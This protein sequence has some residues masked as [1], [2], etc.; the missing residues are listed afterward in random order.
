MAKADYSKPLKNK[1]YELF[2]QAYYVDGKGSRAAIN[3]GYSSKTAYVRASQL[4]T[5]LNIKR[6]IA[7]LSEQTIKRAE[8]SADDVIRE[9]EKIGF[10]N[11]QDYIEDGNSIKDLSKIHRDKAA[12]VESIQV[13]RTVTTSKKGNEY[14][15]KNIKFK[16][17]DKKSALVDLCR[18]HGLFEKDNEQKKTNL[19]DFLRGFKDE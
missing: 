17:Y 5:L 13:T 6:R 16:L 9:L 7:Y 11:L 19:A 12:A 10:S 3:A 8:K 1:K 18:R 14:E 2:C 4:L 15:T